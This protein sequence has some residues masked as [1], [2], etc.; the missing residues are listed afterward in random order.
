[1]STNIQDKLL[2][3]EETPDDNVWN[4]IVAALDEGSL[5]TVG[6][7][8]NE[9]QTPPPPAAWTSIEKQLP[10]PVIPLFRRYG[11]RLRYASAAAAV[12][13]GAFLLSLFYP[14]QSESE[15][16]GQPR[17]TRLSVLP[18]PQK[19]EQSNDDRIEQ[20]TINDVV[21]HVT[22]PKMERLSFAAVRDKESRVRHEATTAS[23]DICDLIPEVAHRKTAIA[24]NAA[25][26]RYMIF[27]REDGNA[28]KLPRKLFD[29][30]ACPAKD[31]NCKQNLREVQQKFASS[32]ISADF[33][34]VL[35]I[36]R[37]LGENQ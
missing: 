5:S 17:I 7:R 19:A 31:D 2:Q 20:P 10:A 22:V 28:V 9:F 13:A 18:L 26:D 25:V 14:K 1:M 8:L 34:G 29:A 15:E 6:S 4:R 27:S 11:K 3:H 30:V 23:L 36:L 12:L 24:L 16:A 32:A 33:T 21:T 37:N 35:E